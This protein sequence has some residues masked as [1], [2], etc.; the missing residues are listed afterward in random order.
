MSEAS[1]YTK[2]NF[3]KINDLIDLIEEKYQYAWN[4]W[5]GKVKINKKLID[6]NL[7]NFF[8]S[9]LMR[10]R[11]ETSFLGECFKFRNKN[12]TNQGQAYDFVEFICHV[13]TIESVVSGIY[14][15]L[16]SEEIYKKEINTTAVFGADFNVAKK[17][18]KYIKDNTDYFSFIRGMCFAHPTTYDWR[19]KSKV[20]FVWCYDIYWA[21][22]LARKMN[23]FKS[24]Q[25]VD[26]DFEILMR[27]GTNKTCNF[28]NLK[29][30]YLT[31]NNFFNFVNLLIDLC[32]SEKLINRVK[33]V[34]DSNKTDR[35]LKLSK[36]ISDFDGYPQFVDY[37]ISLLLKSKV[38]DPDDNIVLNDLHIIKYVLANEE[39]YDPPFVVYLKTHV[40]KIINFAQKDIIK[41]DFNDDI[42]IM[43]DL[44]LRDFINK[45]DPSNHYCSEKFGY[46]RTEAERQIRNNTFNDIKSEVHSYMECL[47]DMTGRTKNWEWSYNLLSKYKDVFNKAFT[48][49]INC[50]DFYT[51][52]LERLFELKRMKKI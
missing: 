46:M 30:I 52:I 29:T 36:Q 1:K 34:N 2:I 21:S 51:H 7:S 38:F 11:N 27:F 17:Q 47:D 35:N 32:C 6:I 49:S 15:K 18:V 48:K 13:S 9:S 50:A 22:S 25:G 28:Y 20:D 10:M 31:V 44:P 37:L 45:Y 8:F 12:E 24:K 4:F 5:K 3:Q 40:N 33:K 19:V 42:S 39:R 26:P 43:D 14:K 16:L 41:L 23:K